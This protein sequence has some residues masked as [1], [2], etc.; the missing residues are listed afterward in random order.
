MKNQSNSPQKA[1]MFAHTNHIKPFT[2]AAIFTPSSRLEPA[3][4]SRDAGHI[5]KRRG[6]DIRTGVRMDGRMMT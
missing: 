5:G 2:E 3:L 6:V 1:I 4:W